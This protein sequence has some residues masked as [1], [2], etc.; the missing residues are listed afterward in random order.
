[1][2]TTES[3]QLSTDELIILR[4]INALVPFADH[5]QQFAT[6]CG[7]G[8]RRPEANVDFISA[9]MAS[10]CSEAY[11]KKIT[12]TKFFHSVTKPE[13]IRTSLPDGEYFLIPD[14][15]LNLLIE[16]EDK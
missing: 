8:S 4:A 1:M 15:E 11:A 16:W 3:E 14:K 12:G 6:C 9:F 13:E 10:G 7:T 2:T 5:T